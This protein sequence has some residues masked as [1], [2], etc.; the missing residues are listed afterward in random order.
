M[1]GLQLNKDVQAFQRKFIGEIRRCEEMER[2][3]R[4]F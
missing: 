1:F 3:L 4:K 2:Q